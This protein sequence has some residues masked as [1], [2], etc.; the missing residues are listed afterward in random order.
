MTKQETNASGTVL[1]LLRPMVH[2]GKPNFFALDASKV[3]DWP[4]VAD[5]DDEE[6]DYVDSLDQENIDYYSVG[7][8]ELELACGG[9]GQEP[10]MVRIQA[11]ANGL[12]VQDSWKSNGDRPWPERVH[13]RHTLFQEHVMYVLLDQ[14]DKLMEDNEDQIELTRRDGYLLCRGKVAENG[15]SISR[16]IFPPAIPKAKK[17]RK[18]EKDES[19]QS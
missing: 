3:R 9:D 2:L 13:I 17:Q 12:Y 16:D 1:E 18:D 4:M 8:E 5:S 19:N 11:D 10:M 14:F 6:D 7:T 15:D